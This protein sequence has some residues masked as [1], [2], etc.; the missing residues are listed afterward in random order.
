MKSFTKKLLILFALF[1][2]T[3]GMAIFAACD[4]DE[5]NDGP[6]PNSFTV[7]VKDE[8]GAAV[9]GVRV[10]LCEIG[11]GA[12]CYNG[13]N[14]DENG[15]AVVG[16]PNAS[17][18]LVVH[19]QDI[20]DYYSYEE[21]EMN[22]GE[23]LTVTL[24]ENK[25]QSGNGTATFKQGL[26]ETSNQFE[27]VDNFY[28]VTQG[29]YRVRV[30]SLGQWVYFAFQ[31]GQTGVYRVSS[32]GT[33]DAKVRELQGSVATGVW[34]MGD[35]TAQDPYGNDNRSES[36]KNF[37]YE[38]EVDSSNMQ[39]SGG[40]VY[41]G[42][43]VM[44]EASLNVD[45]C[46][47]FVRRGNLE[48][49]PQYTVNALLAEQLLQAG[50]PRVEAREASIT[51]WDG[52]GNQSTRTITVQGYKNPATNTTVLKSAHGFA[53]LNA[54]VALNP[55]DNIYYLSSDGTAADGPMLVVHFGGEGDGLG[56]DESGSTSATSGVPPF[57][58]SF[59]AMAQSQSFSYVDPEDPYT[60]YSYTN[61]GENGEFSFMHSYALVCNNDGVYPLTE[62]LKN[63][64]DHYTSSQSFLNNGME[65][66]YLPLFEAAG[67][68]P[69]QYFLWFCS[70]YADGSQS[71][72]Y[73][74][75]SATNTVSAKASGETYFEYRPTA[76]GSYT[77]TV[78][79]TGEATITVGG[80]TH[81]TTGGTVTFTCAIEDTR[82][83]TS[84]SIAL[85]GASA[86]ADVTV[87]VAAAG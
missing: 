2:A 27:N 54:K 59:W 9:T 66:Q 17:N 73:R 46:I 58:A 24:V 65:S 82:N 57:T 16:L 29:S 20:L 1:A 72:A 33:A 30:S 76:A 18:R 51:E 81:Q 41:F 37:R 56:E 5:E 69:E 71:N 40:V 87:A 45:F 53:G 28:A 14:V 11:E 68:G 83:Y 35:G 84:F 22:R 38:F 49:Q 7:Y 55:A 36:D 3:L 25:P 85:T 52:E 64:L 48:P 12:V 79:L 86:D 44:D 34:D 50:D 60:F 8:T 67:A 42:V 15:K 32:T 75:T 4:G 26:G 21:K 47:T 19:I 78:T 39:Q 70:V 23:E 43:T 6:D 77:F 10:Q 80:Q 61:T 63:F 13:V 31:A 74:L 62:E